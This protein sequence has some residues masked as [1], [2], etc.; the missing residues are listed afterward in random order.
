[1]G[2]ITSPN[3][4]FGP[5]TTR[6][7]S[8]INTALELLGQDITTCIRRA[9]GTCCVR[10]QVCTTFNG[11]DLTET[12]DGTASTAVVSNEGRGS[13][14]SEGWSIHTDLDRVRPAQQ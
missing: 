11:I 3:F 4:R 6:A 1:M 2:Q 13:I 9:A 12:A 10:F 14:V 8:S 7:A 5:S